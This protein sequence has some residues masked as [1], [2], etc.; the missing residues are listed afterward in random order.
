MEPIKLYAHNMKIVGELRFANHILPVYNDLEEPL[1]KSSD[2]ADLIGYSEWATDDVKC[3][4]HAIIDRE[5]EADEYYIVPYDDENDESMT[6]VYLN[7]K[8]LYSLL[9]QARTRLARFWR[10]AVWEELIKVRRDNGI[11]V[12]EQF[13]EWD[14]IAGDYYFDDATGKMMKSVTVA[15]GDVEQVEV[16]E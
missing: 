11:N 6:Q 14:M 12:V 13:N 9:A 8:G 2:V 3:F 15:G 7:E 1:F 5:C 4:N 10:R 16:S